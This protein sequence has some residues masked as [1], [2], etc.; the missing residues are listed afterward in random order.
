MLQKTE[1][2][3][4]STNAEAKTTSFYTSKAREMFREIK[5]ADSPA[6]EKTLASITPTL[7][8]NDLIVLEPEVINNLA[9]P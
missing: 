1:M 9:W 6:R 4:A 2:S 5:K 8:P 7:L 3:E